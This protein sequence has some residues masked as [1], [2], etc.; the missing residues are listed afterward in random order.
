MAGISLELLSISD[1]SLVEANIYGQTLN[2]N[3]LDDDGFGMVDIMVRAD[4]G[5]MVSD[6]TITFHLL[7]VND[8]PRIDISGL[9]DNMMKIDEV[10]EIQILDIITDVDD[11]DD[12]IWVTAS[13]VVFTMVLK[14]QRMLPLIVLMLVLKVVMKQALLV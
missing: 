2:I 12:E 14:Q 11:P 5:S 1:E 3:A 9:E 13:N 4:D 8:A 10:L 7:N 6:T